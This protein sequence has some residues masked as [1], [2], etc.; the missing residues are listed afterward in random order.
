VIEWMNS[1]VITVPSNLNDQIS[2]HCFMSSRWVRPTIQSPHL[3]A[4][5]LQRTTLHSDLRLLP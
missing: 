4:S 3:L 1:G 5:R 2:V